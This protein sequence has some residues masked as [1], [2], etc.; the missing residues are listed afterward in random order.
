MALT[1]RVGVSSLDS[2]YMIRPHH[3]TPATDPKAF[4]EEPGRML[5][6]GRQNIYR[7]LTPKIPRKFTGECKFGL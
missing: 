7:R 3:R 1:Q 4:L 6:R 5:F 2:T